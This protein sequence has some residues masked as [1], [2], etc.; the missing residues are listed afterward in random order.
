MALMTAS[1]INIP[2]ISDLGAAFKNIGGQSQSNINGIYGN[3]NNQN[4]A[5]SIARG[6][7]P[8]SYGASRLATG[9]N[10]DTG[11]LESALGGTLGST[12]YKSALGNQQYQQ[13][14]QLANE[15]GM[16]NKPDL[17]QQIFQGIGAVGG[18]AA[19]AYG[20]FKNRTPS[21]SGYNPSYF[22]QGDSSMNP[23]MNDP[24]YMNNPYLNSGYP[25]NF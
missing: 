6:T 11:N 23:S 4:N 22:P 21:T 20:M 25:N 2:Q 16:L 10:L 1:S 7:A 18:P 8:N 15:I 9:Q 5:D 12:M 17:M 3:A 13:Q 24:S 14:S 19:Q